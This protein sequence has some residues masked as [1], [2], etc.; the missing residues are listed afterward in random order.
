MGGFE[1]ADHQN[2]FGN[3][4]DLLTLT[5][6]ESFIEQDY[7]AARSLRCSTV[8]EGICWSR[9]ETAPY[10]YDWSAV[11]R[12]MDKAAHHGIQ[13][14]WDICHFGFPDDLSPLH[15]MF[16]RRFAAICRAFALMHKAHAP[17]LQ[18]IVTPINEVGFLS[19]LGGDARGTVPY[20]VGI[21]C[22]ATQT[23]S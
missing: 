23:T 22:R 4:V 15:P 1:C 6:H 18:L 8:R 5:G 21:G 7:E 9:V 3:R 14:V 12:M 16:P 20:G 11:K 19:W 17:T 13:I 10:Q 2:A